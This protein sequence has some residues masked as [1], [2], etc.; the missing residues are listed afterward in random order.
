MATKRIAYQCSI[1]AV[2]VLKDNRL[3]HSDYFIT[4]ILAFIVPR[5]PGKVHMTS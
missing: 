4:S 5:W 2:V 1:A 3:M